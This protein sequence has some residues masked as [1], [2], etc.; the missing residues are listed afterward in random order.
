MRRLLVA[1]AIGAAALLVWAAPAQAGDGDAVCPTW[2]LRGA[3]GAYPNVVFGEAPAGAEVASGTEVKLVKP[4]EGVQ[5]GVEFATT[6][7]GIEL[8][9]PGDITVAYQLADG[10]K[11]DA[12]AVRLFYYDHVAGSTVTEAPTGFKAADA[13]AGTLTIAG[14]TKVGTV[15]LVYDASNDSAGSVTFTDLKVGGEVVHFTGEACKPPTS[16][17]PSP[18]ATTKAPAGGAPHTTAPATKAPTLPVTGSSFPMVTAAAFG[19]GGVL[20]G[21]AALL[22]FRRRRTRF[23]A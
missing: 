9:Q 18:S 13:D 21:G 16:P 3:T 22:V 4:A 7:A 23:T 19:G 1:A 20:L 15:G 12:G 6:D 14:V 5:P 17:S 11:P 10:A 2:T 8:D